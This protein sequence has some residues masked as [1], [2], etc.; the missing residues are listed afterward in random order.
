MTAIPT[1]PPGVSMRGSLGD[2]GYLDSE[3]YFSSRAPRKSSRGG[4]RFRRGSTFCSTSAFEEAI[5]PALPD[6]KLGED[7]GAAGASTGQRTSNWN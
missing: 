2:Q 7:V 6:A 1:R 3:G 4:G 5:A